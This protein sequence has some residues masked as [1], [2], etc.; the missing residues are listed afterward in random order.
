MITPGRRTTTERGKYN[1]RLRL[2]RNRT[3]QILSKNKKHTTKCKI[4]FSIALQ[5][6]YIKFMEVTVLT[7]SFNYW[8]KNEF[9]THFYSKKYKIK[10]GSGKEPHPFRVIYIVSS[11]KAK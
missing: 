7:L 5:P 11:K 4:K 1:V 2:N 8:N 3:L 10:L 9:L 6:N